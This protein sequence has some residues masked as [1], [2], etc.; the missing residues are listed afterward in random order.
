VYDIQVFPSFTN[1]YYRFIKGYFCVIAL[2]TNLLKTKNNSKFKWDSAAQLAF[3][4]LKTCFS[5]TPILCHFN[6]DLP[7]RLYP[8]AS[9]FVISG[10]FSQ[11][12][13]DQQWHPIAFWS[14]KY[15]TAEINYDIHDKELLV[16]VDCMKY[17]RHYLEEFKKPVQVL[18]NH[19]NLETFMTTKVLTC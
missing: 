6:P 3:D 12:H 13:D 16:I 14:R 7:I 18:T 4:N 5:T 10:I 2:L 19:K 11:L 17:W 9:D 1:F 15:I 8:D